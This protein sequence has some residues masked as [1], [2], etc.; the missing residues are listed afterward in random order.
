MKLAQALA[1][2][3]DLQKRIT[4]LRNRLS[5]NSKVQEGEKPAENPEILLKELDALVLQ[6][7]KMIARINIT[8]TEVNDGKNRLTELLARRDTLEL[9]LSIMRDFLSGAS[10][11]VTRSTK[12]EIKIISTV[13][14]TSLQKEVDK[15]SRELRELD[16]HIQELNWTTELL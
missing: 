16:N 5:L 2:R 7:E 6:L 4:Q 11:V 9:K 13:S 12:T 15:L 1:E 10:S 14:V 8:N 3:A